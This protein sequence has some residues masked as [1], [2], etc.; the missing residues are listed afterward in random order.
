MEID[1]LCDKYGFTW[2]Y[3]GM[4][5]KIKSKMDIWY[6]DDE[7][8]YSEKSIILYHG[9]NNLCSFNSLRGYKKSCKNNWNISNNSIWHRQTS[10]KM[11][12]YEVFR[13]IN[14]HDKKYCAI[15]K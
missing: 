11:N 8:D 13:Y 10:Y 4:Y 15:V 6:I 9:N 12:L 3:M 1:K 7:L 2:G 14:W 5:I